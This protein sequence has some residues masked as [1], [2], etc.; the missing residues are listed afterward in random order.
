MDRL[1]NFCELQLGT[2]PTNP[3]TDGGGESDGSEVPDCK[4][5]DQDPLN[6]DDD[7]VGPILGVIAIPELKRG[8]PLI[9][10]DWSSPTRGKLEF[11]N[12]Y[13]RIL[14]A[15]R[16]QVNDWQILAEGIQGNSFEDEKVKP[17]VEYEYLLEPFIAREGG[18]SA[19]GGLV[20][21]NA[22]LASEDP[23]PPSGS[24]LINDGAPTTGELLVKLSIAAED[25]FSGGD[26][27]DAEVVPGTPTEDLEMRISN[28][29]GFDGA[30]WQPFASTVMDWELGDVA[31]RGTAVVYIQFRD[32]A[33]NVGVSGF[34]QSDSILYD[35]S[36]GSGLLFLPAVF[37][38]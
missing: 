11:V 23:Y 28:S 10:I 20:M 33:G 13:R 3:D 14:N 31:P 4:P 27:G 30:K 12:I 29:A 7:R 37:S 35:P 5:G 2:N 9:L 6:P 25:F 32:E 8:L 16:S 18:G 22:A 21:S 15:Q 17:G 38:P 26:G 36:G 34:A 24:I 19:I 1:T